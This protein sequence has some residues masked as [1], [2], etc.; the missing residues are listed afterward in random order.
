MPADALLELLP[1]L[2]LLMRRDGSV[3]A[4]G[5]GQQVQG[6]RPP[7][8]SAGAA[9]V[10]AWSEA[11][12]ELV[13]LLVRRSIAQRTTLESRFKEAG[14]EYDLRVTA[15]GPDRAVAVIRA[16][17]PGS[18]DESAESTGSR[19]RPELDRRGFIRRFKESMSVAVLREK[20]LAVAVLYIDGLP[21][22][23]QII[24]SRVSEQLMSVAILRLSA[25]AGAEPDAQ[26]RW[27]LGQLGE[28]VLAMVVDTSDRDA[29]DACISNICASLREPLNV[30][31]TLFQL[32][33]YAGVAVLGLDASAPQTLLDRAHAAAAEAR[34]A[35]STD[36][37]FHSD[38]MQL[39]SLARLDLAHELREAVANG[40]IRF[41]YIG[42]HELSTGNLTACV[43]YLR[44]EHPLR[45]EIRPAEFL[46][47]AESTGLAV[48][49]SRSALKALCEDF[50]KLS[51]KW[52]PHV[53]ISFGALRDHLFHQDFLADMDRILADQL[54]ADRLELRIAE[55][56]FVARHASD[57]HA[58]QQRGVQL[59]V[60]EVARDM[61]SI[62]SLARVPVAG[63]QLDRA[64][65]SAILT[66]EVARKVCRA[67]INLALSLGLTP[68]AAGVD[69]AEQREILI[70]M[71]CCYGSGDL[72]PPQSVSNITKRRSRAASA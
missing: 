5:G 42:R 36:V 14:Q 25:Q 40:D 41:R 59:V 55:Q 72:Y 69:A 12:A 49:L 62:A 58:L 9:F 22:I 30:G 32:K 13:K 39:R 26:P 29:L 47:V 20:S 10:P 64:W 54:P 38:T 28:N 56:A 23:A 61:G 1:D 43:G 45:G 70:E 52:A 4:Q 67:G 8:Q 57:F 71:G 50:A 27:Y 68:I 16:V 11:T 7:A 35:G 37:F 66:D 51:R 65:V 17:L 33:P 2:M 18:P 48:E 46:R 15:Q 31:G 24:A 21:D 44:W 19:P 3:I 34:R 53:R 6:L 63:L 60:D